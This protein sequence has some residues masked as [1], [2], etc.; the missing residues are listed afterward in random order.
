VKTVPI[1]PWFLLTMNVEIPR[2]LPKK[3]YAQFSFDRQFAGLSPHGI[4]LSVKGT[5]GPAAIGTIPLLQ[6]K[7]VGWHGLPNFA[8]AGLPVLTPNPRVAFFGIRKAEWKQRCTSLCIHPDDLA[9][10]V[11]I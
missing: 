2:E 6:E 1:G 4:P 9:A 3:D 5:T 10:I 7:P 11:E 8:P